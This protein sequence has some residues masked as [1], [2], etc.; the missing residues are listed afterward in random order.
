MCAPLIVGPFTFPENTVTGVSLLCMLEVFCFPQL[1]EIENPD[2]FQQYGAL[3]HFS[4]IVWDIL[5]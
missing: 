5:K 1:D 2:M 3:P 4:N